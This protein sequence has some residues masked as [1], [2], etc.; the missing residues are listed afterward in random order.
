MK[1][2]IKRL[3]TVVEDAV[4][5]HPATR[6]TAALVSAARGLLSG[7][8]KQRLHHLAR[9]VETSENAARR[10]G[11]AARLEAEGAFRAPEIWK[12]LATHSPRYQEQFT[13]RMT[14]NRSIVLKG[15]A[16]G[17]E[18][19]ALLMT[20]EY[21][22]ARLILGMSPEELA[23]FSANYN[24]I[25]SASWSPTDYAILALVLAS[26]PGRVF[27]QSC[28]YQECALIE[29]FHP[30]LKCL[31]TLPCDWINPGEYTAKPH[32]QRSIDILM[33]ANWGKFKRHWEFFE[34]LAHLP[35][36]LNVVL[37][38][39]HSG[40][41]DK[42]FM[43]GLARE[44]GVRQRLTIYES[45]PIEQ[46]NALQCDAKVSLIMT[47]REGCCVAAVESLMAGCALAMREDAHVGPVAYIN[48]RTG[49][50]LRPGQLAADLASLLQE[51]SRLDPHGWCLENAC[52]QRSHRLLNDLL[53]DHE[54]AEGR[55]WTKDIVMPR[56]HPHPTFAR[57]AE[58]QEMKPVYED[59]TRRFPRVF[60]PSLWDE[61]W[62]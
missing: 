61:S 8:P 1:T 14:L 58:Q 60:A 48:G 19:G 57:P 34:V 37:I 9:A 7:T 27:V 52:N 2:Q 32:D 41:R 54:K 56:W 29:D 20:F 3:L 25:L 53:R 10:R 21:N 50:R 47:R 23:W 44:Y 38:G 16:A 11:W 12:D 40:A 39:Q 42:A 43:E 51:S 31:A 24:L 45:I 28:N 26:V 15:H 33:V 35:E 13:R 30:R 49:R 62:R 22:W 17:G 6:E 36:S 59:L 18:K 4:R 55:P 5:H 46:V